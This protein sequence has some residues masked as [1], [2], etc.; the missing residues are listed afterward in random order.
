MKKKASKSQLELHECPND[1]HLV[2][3]KVTPTAICPW[4][5]IKELKENIRGTADEIQKIL[6][7]LHDE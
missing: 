5:E 7:W 6:D 4:C 1:A 3:W 2:W